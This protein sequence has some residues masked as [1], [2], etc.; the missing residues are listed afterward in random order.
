[1]AT[2]YKYSSYDKTVYRTT[3]K[4]R[5]SKS[6]DKKMDIT[7]MVILG[8]PFEITGGSDVTIGGSDQKMGSSNK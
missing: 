8:G 6:T 2:Y 1:M 7:P 4:V 3:K 5:Y